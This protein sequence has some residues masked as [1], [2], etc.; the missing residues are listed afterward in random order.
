MLLSKKLFLAAL[1]VTSLSVLAVSAYSARSPR[2]EA[3]P[4]GIEIA[5]A[6]P[7]YIPAATG[8]KRMSAVVRTRLDEADAGREAV[9]A[10]K[11]VPV[12]DGDK[13]KVTVFALIGDASNVTTCKGWDD[14]KSVEVDTLVAGLDEEVSVTKLRA[15]GVK[16][17]N[18]DLKFHV[19]PVKTFPLSLP[20]NAPG[21]GCASC[22]SLQCCP[23]SGYCIG[24]SDCGYAC[25]NPL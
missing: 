14:L 7:F 8:D 9:S 15:R 23:N 5:L 4:L 18:G 3:T 2:P 17:E 11:L 16:F 6:K 20:M 21:C 24:C 22:G 19:V 13:V 1:A 12:M 25:C 10:V